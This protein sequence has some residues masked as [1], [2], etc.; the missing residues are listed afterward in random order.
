MARALQVSAIAFSTSYQVVQWFRH[1]DIIAL[2]LGACA[3]SV[4]WTPRACFLSIDS[5]Q[6]GA[7]PCLGES[8][9]A[10]M[11]WTVM[12]AAAFS[13]RLLFTQDWHPVSYTARRTACH[14]VPGPC[15]TNPPG[16]C[17]PC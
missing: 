4:H 1:A 14:T 16:S 8:R 6:S 5:Q 11:P 7:P 15:M 10:A 3:A 17:W 2:G 13:G 9:G 12:G